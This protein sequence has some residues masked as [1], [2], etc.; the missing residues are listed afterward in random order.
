MDQTV[1]NQMIQFNKKKKITKKSL[2]KNLKNHNHKIKQK[3]YFSEK[4]KII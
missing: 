3:L 4:S 2:Y 1:K